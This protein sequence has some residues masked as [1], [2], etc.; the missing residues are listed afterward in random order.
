MKIQLTF[1][2]ALIIALGSCNAPTKD[3]SINI[4]GK[5]KF[6]AEGSKMY[7][8]QYRDREK[9]V[10]DSFDIN[11]DGSYA[12]TMKTDFP[13]EYIL[14]CQKWQSVRFWAEDENLEIDFR[15][16][17]TAKIKIKNPPY[18][19]INGGPKNE[20]INHLNFI[21]YRSYQLMI[22]FSQGVYQ[23]TRDVPEKY[24]DIS[25]QLYGVLSDDDRARYRYLAEHYADQNSVLAVVKR[26]RDKT[27]KE[28]IDHTLATL[29]KANPE[30]PPL[31][32][33]IK[34]KEEARAAAQ[35]VALGSK[36]PHFAYPTPDGDMVSPKDFEG[37]L[38]IIDFWASWCGPCRTEIPHL[39][40]VYE[41][42]RSKG[43]EMLS[44]SIDKKEKDWR[45]ALGEENMAWAQ[46]LAPN[47]GKQTMKDYQFSGIP[48]IIILDKQGKIVAKNLRGEKIDEKLDEL[49]S[50]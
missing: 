42:Y 14:D 37:K 19:Y 5:V 47:A 11:Q 27:D 22:G 16:R 38:L 12:Y 9:V 50:E 30:Y 10:T 24:G 18:V 43:V 49:L 40:E 21:N 6:P 25:G 35:K 17:D 15:G 13:G 34:D 20:L 1:V 4:S 45:K 7:I 32:K 33:Y 29:K 26:L 46:V 3:A 28:L 39:K 8:Y 44:V 23:A 36:A 41:K 31:V 48:F 2:L